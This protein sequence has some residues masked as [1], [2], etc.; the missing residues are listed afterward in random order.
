MISK[1][2]PEKLIQI[3]LLGSCT[4]NIVRGQQQKQK[5]FLIL[6]CSDGEL[7]LCTAHWHRVAAFNAGVLGFDLSHRHPSSSI[8]SNNNNNNVSTINIVQMNLYTLETCFNLI[9]LLINLSFTVVLQEVLRIM[10]YM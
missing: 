6:I 10:T 9:N 7:L 4:R 5:F 2:P 8:C 1:H 3:L